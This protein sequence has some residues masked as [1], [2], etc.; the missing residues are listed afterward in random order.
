MLEPDKLKTKNESP[1]N[2][3]GFSQ[4]TGRRSYKPEITEFEKSVFGKLFFKKSEMG[5][6]QKSVLANVTRTFSMA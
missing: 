1:E 4:V 5:Q 3:S 2:S 6:S